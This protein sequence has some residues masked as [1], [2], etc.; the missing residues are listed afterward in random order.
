MRI[1][2]PRA[3]QI[4]GITS[5]FEMDIINRQILHNLG[6]FSL[7]V[8]FNNIDWLAQL[9]EYPRHWKTQRDHT[10]SGSYSLGPGSE[11][12]QKGKKSAS[13]ASLEVVWG[14]ERVA[15]PPPP[16]PPSQTTAGSLRSPVFFLY[17]ILFGLLGC[18]R[19]P[20]KNKKTLLN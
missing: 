1:T 6:C 17:F 15:E 19:K 14:G 16:F 8:I 18:K 2:R 5:D 7:S 11:L 12:G 4:T 20:S 3:N 13:E 9:F 10:N